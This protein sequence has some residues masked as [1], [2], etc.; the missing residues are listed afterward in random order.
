MKLLISAM[1]GDVS[2]KLPFTLM[3]GNAEPDPAGF[4]SPIREPVKLLG[5]T[6]EEFTECLEKQEENGHRY[7]G[8]KLEPIKEK[9][10]E[11]RDVDVDLIEH[12]EE[13]D[14]T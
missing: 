2:L 3:H 5:K 4:P 10:K 7:K 14:S 11:P 8:S 12:Y 6:S 13:G 1:G 9:L